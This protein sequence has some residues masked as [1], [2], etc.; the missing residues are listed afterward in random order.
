MKYQI[1][2][3]ELEKQI[4]ELKVKNELLER[5]N[6]LLSKILNIII[7]EMQNEKSVFTKNTF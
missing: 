2:I 1:I 6:D 4:E 7:E 3:E 5:Q